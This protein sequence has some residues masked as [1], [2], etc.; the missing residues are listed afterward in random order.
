MLC[1]A[2]KS[3]E[4]LGIA[5]R[6]S[7]HVLHC[8][9]GLL[10]FACFNGSPIFGQTIVS[11]TTTYD[12]Q[13]LGFTGTLKVDGNPTP[14]LFLINGTTVHAGV[15]SLT[16]GDSL[17]GA[18]TLTG[19][20]SVMS[21]TGYLGYSSGV[22]ASVRISDLGS[23]WIQTHDLYVGYSGSGALTVTDRGKA[24]MPGGFSVSIRARS[25]VQRFTAAARHGR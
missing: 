23:Q 4:S 7:V 12:G 19:G 6:S 21:N 8:C 13:T 3:E 11:T 17:G 20:S 14:E 16:V 5:R 18:M 25:A 15:T 24:V 9:A 10:L 1:R 22:A 2:M